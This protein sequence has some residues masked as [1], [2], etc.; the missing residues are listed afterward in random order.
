MIYDSVKLHCLR[1]GVND[2]LTQGRNEMSVGAPELDSL[3][4]V[5]VIHGGEDNL[6]ALLG[7]GRALIVKEKL[8]TCVSGSGK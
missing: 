8:K 6:A 3:F 7:H 5:V 2:A 4:L 1:A